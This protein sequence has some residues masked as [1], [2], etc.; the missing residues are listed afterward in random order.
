MLCLTVLFQ[1]MDKK[2]FQTVRL[3]AH[4]HDFD[5]VTG[6]FLKQEVDTAFFT[7]IRFQRG[8]I[9]KPQTILPESGDFAERGFQIQDKG[10]G[11]QLAQ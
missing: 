3:V 1:D 8:V 4:T 11:L 2:L 9:H 5:A 6:E 10:F 7:D